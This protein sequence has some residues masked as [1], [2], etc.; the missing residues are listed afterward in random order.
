MLVYM[1]IVYVHIWTYIYGFNQHSFFVFIYLLVV[2]PFPQ[3]LLTV[4]QMNAVD[5]VYEPQRHFIGKNVSEQILKYWKHN[6]V[7]KFTFSRPLA[8]TAEIKV[9]SP[10]RLES[11]ASRTK[12]Q[13]FHTS[14]DL[15]N[16]WVVKIFYLFLKNW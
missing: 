7:E 15:F 2:L 1:V 6:E 3:L 9:C 5:P 13:H 4:L 16:Y 8:H 14:F 11:S 10:T 12:T